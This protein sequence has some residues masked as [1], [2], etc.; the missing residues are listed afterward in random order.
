L[1]S[2]YPP[3]RQV[4]YQPAPKAPYTEP[5]ITVDGQRLVGA[6]KFVYLG[7]TL[8]RSANIDEEVAHRVARASASFGRLRD[9]VWDRRGL[10]VE[11]KL[12]VYKAVVLPSLLYACETWTIYSRH[13]KQLNAF[14]MRCLRILLRIKW[15]DKVPDTEVLQ[16]AEMESIHATL[17]RSQLRWAGHVHRMDDSRLPKRLLYGELTHGK[18]C[19]GRPRLRFKDTLKAALK[20]CEIPHAS[21]EKIADDR[22]AW[23][24]AVK[25]GVTVF[26]ERRIT[27]N[28]MKRQRRKE[29]ANSPASSAP[30]I[31]CPHCSR[32]FRAKIGLISHLRTHPRPPMI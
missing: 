19:L 27:D 8:S 31:P 14:H 7:S 11:T 3:R 1:A 5:V 21:W 26:E 28:E 13:A 30:Q 23:R 6:D 16:R 25:A 10:S 4:L 18:R 22:S 17:M 2:P 20:S 32:H 12:K 24:A 9:K 15:Q 29:S